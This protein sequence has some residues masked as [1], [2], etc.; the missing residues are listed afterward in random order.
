LVFA[1]PRVQFVKNRV[2][3]M[4]FMQDLTNF[5]RLALIWTSNDRLI[6]KTTHWV[7]EKTGT[8]FVRLNLVKYWLM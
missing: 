1:K 7:A 8:L 5:M 4:T 6:Y 2:I 3:I